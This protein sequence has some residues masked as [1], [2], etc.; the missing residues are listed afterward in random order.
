[1]SAQASQMSE[2]CDL[3]RLRPHRK[4]SKKQN[5]K[6]PPSIF[7]RL[8]RGLD[9]PRLSILSHRLRKFV[10]LD[11]HRADFPYCQDVRIP[12]SR[13]QKSPEVAQNRPKGEGGRWPSAC[14][15]S[16]LLPVG[17]L[18]KH[19]LKISGI[20]TFSHGIPHRKFSPGRRG[21]QPRS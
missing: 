1:M 15:L 7:S 20:V 13:P 9:K 14:G 12:Q 2:S 16:G 19:A 18:A 3:H 10:R 11:R 5:T 8:G 4:Q 21:L 17:A 6:A